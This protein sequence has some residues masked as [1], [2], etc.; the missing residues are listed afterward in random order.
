MI[1]FEEKRDKASQL[2]C[3]GRIWENRKIFHLCDT[4]FRLGTVFETELSGVQGNGILPVGE[5][6]L[7]ICLK[8]G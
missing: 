3:F 7:A 8:A 2:H 6:V 5:I 1:F 4:L